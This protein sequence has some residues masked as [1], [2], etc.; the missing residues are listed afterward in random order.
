MTQ[1]LRTKGMHILTVRQKQIGF[2]LAVLLVSG[3]SLAQSAAVINTAP[4][5]VSPGHANEAPS[6][7]VVAV[8]PTID[9][10]H[11]PAPINAANN[12]GAYPE[13]LFAAAMGEILSA[14]HQAGAAI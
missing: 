8:D 2:V 1:L 13:A 6:L 9:P 10:P 5:D 14:D 12:E 3:V 11:A 4:P 7:Q